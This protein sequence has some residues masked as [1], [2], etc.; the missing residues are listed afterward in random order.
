MDIRV[1]MGL[2]PAFLALL[3]N[4]LIGPSPAIDTLAP[5]STSAD[6]RFGSEVPVWYVVKSFNDGMCHAGKFLC[7]GNGMTD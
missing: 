5:M 2:C 7:N 1:S 6:T 4:C 3:V